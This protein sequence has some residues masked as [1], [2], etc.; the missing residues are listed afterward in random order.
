MNAVQQQIKIVRDGLIL[1][2]SDC[3]RPVYRKVVQDGT[4]ELHEVQHSVGNTKAAEQIIA[5]VTSLSDEALY[6][7]IPRIEDIARKLKDS[8]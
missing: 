5:G 3:R 8:R 7:L 6:Y 1:L 2:G 4:E